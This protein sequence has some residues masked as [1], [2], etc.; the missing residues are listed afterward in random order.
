MFQFDTAILCLLRLLRVL[1]P[2]TASG[3]AD[4][5]GLTLRT[6]FDEGVYPGTA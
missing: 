1:V 6:L 4:R 3:D 5:T 2:V